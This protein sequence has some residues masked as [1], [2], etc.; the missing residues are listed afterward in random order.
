MIPAADGC[1]RTTAGPA[2]APPIR[3]SSAT[4]PS[5]PLLDWAVVPERDPRR[6]WPGPLPHPPAAYI[7]A[8]L[9][10][11]CEGKRLHHR[12]APFLVE[13]PLLVLELG[14]RPVPDP[15]QPYGFDV[16]AHRPVRPLAAP[17]AADPRPGVL[18]ALLAG[19]VR[20]LQAEIPELGHHRR[21]RRQAHLRLGAARTTPRSRRPTAS[22]RR[23][24]RAAT[25]T[26]GWASSG[27]P[28]RTGGEPRRSTCGA[29]APAS[30]VPPTPATATWCW[31]SS[32]SPSTSQDIT[33]YQPALRTRR[34][35][36]LGRAPTNL[37]ADAAFDAWH[38]YQ[39][40]AAHGG[41]AAIPLNRR[42]AAR[43]RATP[44]G[45]RCCDQGL[46]DDPDHASSSTRMATARSATAAPCSG[47]SPTGRACAHARF[48]TGRLR[49]AH[50]PRTRRADAGRSWTGRRE[51]TAPIYRQRT[52]AE[53]INSQAT[54]LGIERPKV[55][56]R[57]APS[58][59]STPSPTSSSTSARC[60]ASAP[61]NAAHA[62]PSSLC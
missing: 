34:A 24:S 28:T 17:P 49:Q 39:T 46:D 14:F 55:R 3:W 8:L 22:T 10:K 5:L 19:T 13:H 48:A 43:R 50:Q 27:A 52:S 42:G 40:C 31:P 29:T 38:V 45:T 9:V 23:A 51:P 7:K 58:I 59:A 37:A 62:P 33:Y 56:T 2:R 20:A 53:R 30:S 47:R 35:A 41:L 25:P 44:P 32:P 54:A 18:G 21:R 6:P 11:L 57:R 26:A 16:G 12:P 15:T 4:A 61:L 36:A 1:C 60:S